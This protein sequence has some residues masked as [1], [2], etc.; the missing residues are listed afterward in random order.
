MNHPEPTVDGRNP[1]PP[2]KPW[3]DDSHVNDDK[4]WFP[5]V[6]SWCRSLPTHRMWACLPIGN[7]QMGCF[8]VCFPLNL[9]QRG[10]LRKRDSHMAVGQ[11]QWYHFGVGAPPILVYFSGWIGMF[12][13]AIWEFHSPGKRRPR[14]MMCWQTMAPRTE[15][16]S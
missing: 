2:K 13:M 6:S 12:T 16:S 8:S 10:A 15:V 1:A 3:N 14:P 9:P 5:M 11:N 7:P 4:Q